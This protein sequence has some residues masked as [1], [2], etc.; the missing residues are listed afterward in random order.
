MARDASEREKNDGATQ[1]PSNPKRVS[2]MEE[3]LA[4]TDSKGKLPADTGESQNTQQTVSQNPAL[5]VR[6]SH[7]KSS[8]LP[9]MLSSV[10]EEAPGDLAQ[11][12]PMTRNEHI[13]FEVDGNFIEV[14]IE[15]EKIPLPRYPCKRTMDHP[16]ATP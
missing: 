2:R 16:H 6:R 8:F 5:R 12:E 1:G 7:R 9:T 15:A 11:Q 10:A 4:A 3:I 14:L 13:N